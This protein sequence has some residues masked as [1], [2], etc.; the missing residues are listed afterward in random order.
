[1]FAVFS[2]PVTRP[3][4]EMF[5]NIKYTVSCCSWLFTALSRIISYPTPGKHIN[6][7]ANQ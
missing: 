6:F 7:K 3:I 2:H 1:M 4:T 5:Y